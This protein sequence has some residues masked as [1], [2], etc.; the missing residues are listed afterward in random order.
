MTDP[1]AAFIGDKK[2]K[3]VTHRRGWEKKKDLREGET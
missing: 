2:T 3:R 1:G